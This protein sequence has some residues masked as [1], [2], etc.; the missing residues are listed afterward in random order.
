MSTARAFPID[1]GEVLAL[2]EQSAGI[3]VWHLDVAT[4]QLHGTPQFFRMM[5]L[6]P[7]T[8]PVPLE[9]TTRLRHPDDKE[10]VRHAYCDAMETGV[11]HC[12]VEYRIVRPDGET[13]WLLGRGQV[14]RNPDGRVLRYTGVNLDVTES[15]RSEAALRESEARFRRVF[16]QSPLGKATIDAG[17]SLRE[18]NPALC[19]MLGYAPEELIGRSFLDM[20]H[21]DDRERCDAASRG[22]IGGTLPQAQMEER[23]V[24]KSGEAFWVSITIGPIRDLSGN[25]LYSLG[26]I[27]DI[28]ERKRI[29]QALQDSERRLRELNEHLEQLAEERARQLASSR[30]RLQAFFDNAL[31]WLTLIRASPDGRFVFVDLN[32]TSEKAYGLP[33]AQVVERPVEAILGADQAQVPMHFLRE[34]M[35]TGAP[36]RYVARRTLAGRTTAIDVMFV[37]VPPHDDS[38]DRYIITTAR[39]IT[40]REALEAQLRQAQ[41]MEAIGKLTGGVAHDFNNLL[42][43]ISGN[44]ELAK[45]GTAARVPRLMDNILRAGE[46][47]VALTRQ[48]LSF[49]R[50]QSANPQVLDLRAE[51]PR[52]ADMLRASLKGNIR[53]AM[54]V[55][56]DVWPIEVD[57]AEFE[58]AV[59]NVAANARDAMPDGGTFSIDVSNAE[60]LS[61]RA[62]EACP[63]ALDPGVEVR[64][65]ESEGA[66][67]RTAHLRAI[68]TVRSN[69]AQVVIALRDTGTGIPAELLGKVFD[70]FFTTKEPGEGTGLGLSQVYGF[71]QQS[72]GTASIDSAPGRGTTVTLRLPCSDKAIAAAS[73]PDSTATAQ[74]RNERILLVEDNPEVATVTAQMLGLMG[75][76]VE[77]VD[78]ARKALAK[79]DAGQHFDLLLT[80]VVMPD[81]MTGLDLAR[82]VRTRFPSLPTI[83]VSGYND[84]VNGDGSGFMVLRKPVP[85]QEL[86]RCICVCLDRAAAPALS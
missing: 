75:F 4:N 20:V 12:E 33:R 80:D 23:F 74:R 41:K 82:T 49:S 10:R 30:A 69:D 61:R 6:E 67:N 18:V 7:T 66:A 16:E 52:I 17:F 45:R 42:A 78:R 72:G 71:A 27:E 56:D 81:G 86:S 39:D 19:C 15:K 5:G 43:V 62:G 36:Q 37:L 28:D 1:G 55:A 64:S 53:L 21:P 26:I 3:G 40:E 13:R 54:T 46:R 73:A 50:R 47:G 48:L 8:G 44:A 24:R 34:C 32:P 63:R 83:L 9:T 14:T 58:I 85:F 31:D 65:T 35:R 60:N 51:I 70:P 77:V 22:L 57:L 76:S 38:A 59:L 84:V 25:I 11:D 68:R 2:A 79:L 29:T